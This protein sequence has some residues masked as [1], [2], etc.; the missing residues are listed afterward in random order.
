MT[1]SPVMADALADLE[2]AFGEVNHP[3][4]SYTTPGLTVDQIEAQIKPTGLTL[5]D[6][7]IELWSWRTGQPSET[8]NRWALPGRFQI[9]TLTE[10]IE[11][12]QFTIDAEIFELN[13]YMEA[14]WITA[15]RRETMEFWAHTETEQTGSVLVTPVDLWDPGGCEAEAPQCTV[16]LTTVVRDMARMLRERH[17]GLFD[18]PYTKGRVTMWMR[19]PEVGDLSDQDLGYAW[20]Y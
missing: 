5:P 12:R 9:P 14:S 10:A 6:E 4:A 17:W 19:N 18:N 2:A 3:W 16:P 7:L 8:A 15:L 20:A 11:A 13:A 1:V